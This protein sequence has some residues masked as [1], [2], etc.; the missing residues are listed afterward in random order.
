MALRLRQA[1]VTDL[2]S[3]YRGEQDYIRCW[4]PD[5][6]DTWR[7]QLERHLVRWVENF[8]R[9]TVAI[10]DEQFAGYSLWTPEQDY[11]ELSTINVSQ[12]YRRNG[13]G[14]TLLDAYAATVKQQGFTHLRLS[15]RPDNPAGLMYERAGFVCVGTDS[16]GYLRYER[17]G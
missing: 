1:C 8:D 7:L 9:L 2:P 11:A 13:I 3:I 17:P 16:H 12:A 14:R 5:H 6:E 10:I 4:E 15:V